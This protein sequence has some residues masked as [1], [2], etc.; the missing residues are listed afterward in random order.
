[1]AATFFDNASPPAPS[2]FSNALFRGL[3]RFANETTS[4]ELVYAHAPAIR[5]RTHP[6]SAPRINYTLT[7]NKNQTRPLS[8]WT[9]T[10]SPTAVGFSN[11]PVYGA[12]YAPVLVTRG[13]ELGLGRAGN[14]GDAS[15]ARAAG[16]FRAAWDA[17]PTPT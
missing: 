10:D 1:M 15:L 17:A 14:P 11:R 2:A 3:F 7:P 16:I 6:K 9:N 8:D 13:K 5:I 12:M 4:R